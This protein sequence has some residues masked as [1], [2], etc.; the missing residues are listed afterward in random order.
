MPDFPPSEDHSQISAITTTEVT[1][2]W[3]ISFAPKVT[4]PRTTSRVGQR[5]R[6]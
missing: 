2:G 6:N 1:R 4:A 5:V 3:R